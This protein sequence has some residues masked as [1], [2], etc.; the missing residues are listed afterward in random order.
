[1][2][3]FAP[4]FQR[5]LVDAHGGLSMS[6]FTCTKMH[7]SWYVSDSTPASRAASLQVWL[8]MRLSPLGGSA[9]LSAREQIAS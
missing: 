5:G 9:E 6:L 2:T 4:P 8:S 7:A 3:W 1:M